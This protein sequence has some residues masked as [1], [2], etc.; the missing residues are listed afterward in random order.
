MSTTAAD[1]ATWMTDIITTERRVTQTDMVDA[2][3]AKFGSDWIYVNDNGHPSIDRAV[4]KEFRKAHRGA[5]KWN[6]DDRAWYVDDEPTAG[7]STE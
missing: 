1:I 2:I 6:R 4:L 3:D 5:V 7:T